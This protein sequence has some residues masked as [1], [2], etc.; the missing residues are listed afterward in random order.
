MICI[1]E[2][3]YNT[4]LIEIAK[5]YH[6]EGIGVES[7]TT[8]L[9]QILSNDYSVHSLLIDKVAMVSK[10][11]IYE[12]LAKFLDFIL[13]ILCIPKDDNVNDERPH[14]FYPWLSLVYNLLLS[15][16][17]FKIFREQWGIKAVFKLF[18]FEIQN[19]ITPSHDIVL[20]CFK[21]FW[22]YLHENPED[23][24]QICKFL[25]SMNKLWEPS[26]DM[27]LIVVEILQIT[28]FYLYF[29]MDLAITEKIS[30]IKFEILLWNA[31]SYQ[32]WR[33]MDKTL[34]LLFICF[35]INSRV[36]ANFIKNKG[37]EII[38]EV[39]KKLESFSEEL[40]ETLLTFS[41][42]D[43]ITFEHILK[44]WDLNI[45]LVNTTQYNKN[46]KAISDLNKTHDSKHSLIYPIFFNWIFENIHKLPANHQEVASRVFERVN[47]IVEEYQDS[48]SEMMTHGFLQSWYKFTVSM[49]T[50]AI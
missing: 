8:L 4:K 24:S 32:D 7:F 18:L 40:L 41:I 47:G 30:D 50:Y 14:N 23:V 34:K 29:S 49:K 42:N 33:V 31:L 46:I 28:A 44:Y 2:D 16:S 13:K 1:G 22:E 38:L 21:I 10:Y 26:E 19:G 45:D 39:I 35:Q 25:I 9:F 36:K 17:N 20:N 6:Y 43:C 11:K 15:T 48:V 5:I 27:I 37:I 12:P 3:N